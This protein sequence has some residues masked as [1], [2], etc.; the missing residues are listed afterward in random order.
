[1]AAGFEQAG[2]AALSV[3][4]DEKFFQGSLADLQLASQSTSLPCL[5]KDFMI[6]EF[7]VLEARASRADVIL[8]IVAALT[9]SELTRLRARATELELDV[10][11]EVHDADELRRAADLEVVDSCGRHAGDAC[12]RRIIR[13][14]KSCGTSARRPEA[15]P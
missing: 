3:L 4:T 1:M 9:D 11:C 10:L 2:A 13:A 12:P 6:D 8:L 15:H 14:A 7:Q 5:R